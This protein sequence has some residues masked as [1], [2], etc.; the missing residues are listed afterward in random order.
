MCSVCAYYKRHPEFKI[1]DGWSDYEIE[2]VLENILYEKVDVLN[3][4]IPLLNGKTLRQLVILLSTDLLISQK[5]QCVTVNCSYC[6]K[7]K[8]IPKYIYLKQE[9]HFC[10]KSCSTK[11]KNAFGVW[12][13]KDN[14]EQRSG[15][16]ITC[17]YCGKEYYVN[18]SKLKRITNELTFHTCSK[19]CWS[20]YMQ[21]HVNKSGKDHRDYKERVK[22]SCS[23]C[24]KEIEVYELQTKNINK[25]GETNIFCS[26]E[27]ANK[28]KSTYSGERA[29]SRK[30]LDDPANKKRISE[31]ARKGQ[32]QMVKNGRKHTNPHKK[33]NKI[34]DN[35]NFAYENEKSCHHYSLDV[36]LIDFGLYVEIMG[37]YYHS[38]PTVEKYNSIDK[39]NKTQRRVWRNDKAKRSNLCKNH[40]VKILNL[41]ESDINKRPQLCEDL[42]KLFIQKDGVLDN[43]NSFN[44]NDNLTLNNEIVLPY[45]ER[46]SDC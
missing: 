5:K 30:Y 7:I 16:Y 36:A 9:L 6:G 45:F 28:Y 18:Q 24:G 23:Y 19:K 11:Y 29:C 22:W 14:K 13:N 3:E 8:T 35:N 2:I 34:L 12:K 26:K 40:G 17:D 21:E 15:V 10:N 38:N 43:Y 42:I 41:W 31:N 33:V 20:K 44:Y 4:I 46:S 37:D 25:H 1:P 32:A 27:C 39:M